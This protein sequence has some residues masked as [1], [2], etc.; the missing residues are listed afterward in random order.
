MLAQGLSQELRQAL[1]VRDLV[2]ET[3]ARRR[4]TEAMGGSQFQMISSLWDLRLFNIVQYPT[5]Q[6]E[7]DFITQLVVKPKGISPL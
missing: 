4:E 6:F 5:C 7:D 2:V 1:S 3:C